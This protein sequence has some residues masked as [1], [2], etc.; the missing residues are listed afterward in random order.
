MR[1]KYEFWGRGLILNLYQGVSPA[2]KKVPGS[3]RGLAWLHQGQRR[4]PR[5]LPRLQQLAR[6]HPSGSSSE[7]DFQSLFKCFMD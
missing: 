2:G 4:A 1:Q 6:G 5:A 7:Q 3:D